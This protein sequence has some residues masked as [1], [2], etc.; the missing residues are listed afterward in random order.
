MKKVI[1]TLP[2]AVALVS[3]ATPPERSV[4]QIPR[5]RMISQN[6]PNYGWQSSKNTL[7]A[8]RDSA[9]VK[10]YA[11]KSYVDPNNPDVRMPSGTMHVMTRPSR[12][13]TEP[14]TRNGIVVEPQYASVNSNVS[15]QVEKSQLARLESKASKTNMMAKDAA[16]QSRMTDRKLEEL[17]TKIKKLEA[18]R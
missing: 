18:V 8:V 13:N 16:L 2:L 10:G 1:L 6:N 9:V 11:I 14:L 17:E 15:A 4:R 12:W 7:D 5:Q 3:C